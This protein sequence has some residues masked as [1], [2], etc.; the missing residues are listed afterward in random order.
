MEKQPLPQ[1]AACPNC[2]GEP[3]DD[4]EHHLRAL[5]YTH[6]DV[7]CTCSDCGRVW[8]N[9]V[10]IGDVPERYEEDM[11]CDAC[12][13]S[14]GEHVYGRANWIRWQADEERFAIA[15]KC[16]SC[17]YVWSVI[18]DATNGGAMMGDPLIAGDLD[19]AD[20]PFEER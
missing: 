15:L 6:D 13:E 7:Q 10:P 16:P 12:Y 5:G 4:P 19:E 20:N 11:R 18:R 9:G 3:E 1:N 8:T 14:R 17:N 2:G